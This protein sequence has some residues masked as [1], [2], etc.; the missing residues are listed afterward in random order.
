MIAT[1]PLYATFLD[2][3]FDPSPYSPISRLHWNEAY[4]RDVTTSRSAAVPTRRA[5]V[6]WRELARVAVD[7]LVRAAVDADDSSSSANSTVRGRASRRRLVRTVHGIERVDGRRLVVERSH[8][9]GP[10]SSPIE[11]LGATRRRPGRCVH[12]RS[13]CR[14]V[15][16]PTG[17]RRGR[18]RTSSP[19]SMS[20]GA[21]PDTF[22]TE[23]QN[24]GFPP[25]LPGAMQ[26][27]GLRA[28]AT[29]DR[30][31]RPPLSTC[32]G[33]ITSWPCTGCGGCPTANPPIEA[34]TSR[35][36]HDELL[37]VIAAEAASVAGPHRRREPRHRPT[38]GRRRARRLE[39]ARNVRGAVPTSAGPPS[40]SIPA[41][42]VA[43]V[44]THDMA[45]FAAVAQDPAAA[46]ELSAYRVLL[47]PDATPER[48]LLDPILERLASSDAQIV[49]ADL[50]DLI[51]ETRPH[52]LPGTRRRRHLAATTRP[53]DL[54]DAGRRASSA[55][56]RSPRKVH[57]DERTHRRT[58]TCFLFGEGTHRYLH[59]TFGAQPR[60]R[61]HAIRRLGTER[62]A[63]RGRR[64]VRRLDARTRTDRQRQWRVERL[65]RRR[66]RRRS[67]PVPRD[68]PA[69][70]AR[71]RSPTRS[72]RQPRRRR[73]SRRS[74]P[75]STTTGR[76]DDWMSTAR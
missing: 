13:T 36:P 58:S 48:P 60:R 31:R 11:Q 51:D 71:S 22:F 74:S 4:H 39:R 2:E 65:G 29:D 10:V 57:L 68:R 21:P 41:R 42:S 63:S 28:V 33:S 75:T 26:P 50:D 16:I 45:P 7:Q 15:P 69:R 37:A 54:G 70:H 72:A 34:C 6:D 35:Y 20:V 76:D 30:P 19:T 44:R 49:V 46:D 14:S 61:R 23:G 24:W 56:P 55:S 9:L 8:V 47:G 73:A 12:C 62:A 32:C 43:G 25:Q 52:N 64:I 59:R 66:R 5:H 17:G 38:R 67:V 3:P 18:T 1:L 40:P 27:S 53:T